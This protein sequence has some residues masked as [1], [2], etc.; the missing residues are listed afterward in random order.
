MARQYPNNPTEGRLDIFAK[1]VIVVILIVAVA[2]V[3]WKLMPVLLMA[4]IGALIAIMLRGL[5]GLVSRFLPISTDRSLLIVLLILAGG[6]G[7]F[8]WLA[9]SLISDQLAQFTE[10]IP[11]SKARLQ[12]MLRGSSWGQ[13]ILKSISNSKLDL[14]QGIQI[15]S[16]ITQIATVTMNAVVGLVVV[17]F[18]SVYFS[19][20]PGVYTRGLIALVPK[21]KSRRLEEVLEATAHTLRYWMLGQAAS[22]IIMALLTSLGLWLV[23]VPLAFLLGLIT[24]LFNI[25]PYLG[26]IVGAIPGVLIALTQDWNTVLYAIVVY[27]AVHQLEGHLVS[28]LAQ[29]KA[30]KLPPA[31]IIFAVVAFGLMF[32]MLGILMATPLTVVAMVWIKMLYVHDVLEKPVEIL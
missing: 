5:A 9:G 30:I 1:R 31:L 3:I 26:A 21:E 12:Q 6:G 18:T 32:G 2:A 14:D 7:L 27:V 24:G 10:L 17:L 28:P 15:F 8:F 4:F 16:T 13:Q 22:M 29:N 25:V 11:T 19:V 20:N 23:G